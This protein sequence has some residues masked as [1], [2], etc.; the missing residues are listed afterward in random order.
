MKDM[1]KK[2]YQTPHIETLQVNFEASIC[3]NSTTEEINKL[4]NNDHDGT[5]SIASGGSSGSGSSSESPWGSTT[6]SDKFFGD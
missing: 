6:E 1:I 4:W 3:N 2:V 5:G